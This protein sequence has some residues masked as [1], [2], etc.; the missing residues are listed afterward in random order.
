MV[1]SNA[2]ARSQCGTTLPAPRS[3]IWVAWEDLPYE[4]E[5]SLWD[6]HKKTDPAL[7]EPTSC[8]ASFVNSRYFRDDED[9]PGLNVNHVRYIRQRTVGKIEGE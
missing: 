1:S 2:N 7:C 9:T 6:K 5:L 4:T 3:D 8:W